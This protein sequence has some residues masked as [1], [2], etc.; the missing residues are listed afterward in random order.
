MNWDRTTLAAI[1]AALALVGCDS[2]AREVD[3]SPQRNFTADIDA[4]L[5]HGPTSSKPGMVGAQEPIGALP[6]EI[7]GSRP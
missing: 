2:G 3:Y 6:W 7:G 4:S 1:I 5:N